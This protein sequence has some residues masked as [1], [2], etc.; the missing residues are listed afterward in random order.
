MVSEVIGQHLRT[1]LRGMGAAGKGEGQGLDNYYT[2]LTLLSQGLL[3]KS[4]NRVLNTACLSNHT[5][6]LPSYAFQSEDK[7]SL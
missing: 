2:G 1:G 5:G 4:L 6:N 3:S 7:V